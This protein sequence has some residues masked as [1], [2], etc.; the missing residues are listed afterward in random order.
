MSTGASPQPHAAGGRR[1]EGSAGSRGW[2]RK[3]GEKGWIL[4]TS[5]PRS[6]SLHSALCATPLR[7]GR[8]EKG[9]GRKAWRVR[10]TESLCLTAEKHKKGGWHPSFPSAG[11]FLCRHWP[12]TAGA[13]LNSPAAS[14]PTA[15]RNHSGAG[16]TNPSSLVFLPAHARTGNC[17]FHIT[18]WEFPTLQT[19]L[20]PECFF[21][22]KR[23]EKHVIN[24]CEGNPLCF[25][26]SA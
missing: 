13:A 16:D 26:L 6:C 20:K 10:Q 2:R 1:R 25:L 19:C 5:D 23:N 9:V 18:K 21:L 17:A 22:R 15:Y 24:F 14:I 12:Q 3:R 4:R 8:T 7:R 11:W